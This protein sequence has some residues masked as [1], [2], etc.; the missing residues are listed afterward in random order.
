MIQIDNDRIMTD[1]G[2]VRRMCKMPK[3]AR[4]K[5]TNRSLA[6]KRWSDKSTSREYEKSSCETEEKI[7]I[8]PDDEMEHID[9]EI[10][11]S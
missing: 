10:L 4:Q 3:V 1:S 6:S 2:Q 11:Q 7:T 5:T 8:K 9:E